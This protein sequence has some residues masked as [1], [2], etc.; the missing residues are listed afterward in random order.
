MVYICYI[1]YRDYM[2]VC[3]LTV[4]DNNNASSEVAGEGHMEVPRELTWMGKPG[5]PARRV[6]VIGILGTAGT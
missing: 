6:Q 2:I 5:D 4:G 1:T 3:M